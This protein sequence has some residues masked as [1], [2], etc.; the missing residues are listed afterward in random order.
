MYAHVRTYTHTRRNFY[1]NESAL[2]HC[3]T[4]FN[5]QS[6]SIHFYYP[7]AVQSISILTP[8]WLRHLYKLSTSVINYHPFTT[9]FQ[10]STNRSIISH[11]Y[12]IHYYRFPSSLSSRTHHIPSLSNVQSN[13]PSYQYVNML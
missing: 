6:D 13:S 9:I 10:L 12:P 7:I 8:Y 3:Q 11:S 2:H 5:H 4:K 1:D